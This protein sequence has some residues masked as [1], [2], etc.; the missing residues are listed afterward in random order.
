[1]TYTLQDLAPLSE[2]AK[3]CSERLV[4]FPKWLQKE[5]RSRV[6]DDERRSLDLRIENS[7]AHYN[8]DTD[9]VETPEIIVDILG[10]WEIMFDYF[11]RA[12]PREELYLL[13]PN[14]ELNARH[15]G[16]LRDLG[17][18]K[19]AQAAEDGLAAHAAS[20]KTSY[21]LNDLDPL[22]QASRISNR[23]F[24][25]LPEKIIDG[26]FDKLP[27]EEVMRF[28]SNAARVSRISALS[29]GTRDPDLLV[30]I[31]NNLETLHGLFENELPESKLALMY[32]SYGLDAK[33]IEILRDLGLPKIAKAF[34]NAL[35]IQAEPEPVMIKKYI[36]PRKSRFYRRTTPNRFAPT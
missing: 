24:F 25:G 10:Y 2:I 14:N 15:V 31:L 8:V 32:S 4:R 28:R 20:P 35:A 1:M 13:C 30:D 29:G 11:G 33:H 21:T 27:K 22:I 12:I 19:L 18:S 7:A 6:T 3:T 17:F 34:E 23:R 5:I 36:A 9:I 26:V 16:I